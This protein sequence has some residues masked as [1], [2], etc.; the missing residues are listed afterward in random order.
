MTDHVSRRKPLSIILHKINFKQVFFYIFML[1]L[2]TFQ[3]ANKQLQLV[4]TQQLMR[5]KVV[6]GFVDGFL[7]LYRGDWLWLRCLFRYAF[8]SRY[9]K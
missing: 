9:A 7:P 2:E 5:Q 8:A 4:V 6:L 3:T 1:L